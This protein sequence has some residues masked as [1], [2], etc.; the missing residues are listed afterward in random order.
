MQKLIRPHSLTTDV[1]IFTIE[2]GKL[3]ILL[4]K[5]ANDPFKNKWALPGGFIN[6]NEGSQDAALR[7]LKNKAGL[8][9]VYLEQLY[10]F[11]GS[12]RDPRGRVCTVVYFALVL[13]E[14][15]K[16]E[17]GKKLQTPVFYPV[18]KLPQLAFDHKKIVTYAIKRLRSKLE[19]T[20]AVYALLPKTFTFNQL[21][22]TY[23]AIFGK[24][25]DKRNFRKKFSM[26]KLIKPT[27]KILTGNRQRP[28]RLYYFI[29][30]KPAELK[31]FF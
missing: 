3:K 12:S 1:I 27:K 31:K 22:T 16:F 6:D 30:R 10:T 13:L 26:L 5:R 14:D 7:V 11:D 8:K 18:N 29:N 21:Q 23:E 25:M 4:I 19:Y 17:S 2:N 20:N 9:N 15:I 28:A 24:N